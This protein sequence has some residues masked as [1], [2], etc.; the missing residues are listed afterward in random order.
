MRASQQDGL[1]PSHRLENFLLTYRST[2]HATTNV[3]PCDL[4]LGRRI[5]TRLDLVKPNL[6]RKVYERQAG[7][8]QQHDQHARLREFTTGQSVWVRNL[9]PGPSWVPGKIEQQLGPLTFAV[10][11][12][13]GQKWERNVDHLRERDCGNPGS[14]SVSSRSES[15][16]SEESSEFMEILLVTPS[17]LP[18]SQTS[19]SEPSVVPVLDPEPDADISPA[20]DSAT[21][22]RY[23]SRV[24]R[25][26]DRLSP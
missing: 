18:S 10:S 20:H 9:R 22:S 5:R 8:K 6:E 16:G 13:D 4:F 15:H 11:V 12:A 2:P 1:T 25:P 26:P 19:G 23:P 21:T 24:R 14:K 17:S 3:A 7:Q